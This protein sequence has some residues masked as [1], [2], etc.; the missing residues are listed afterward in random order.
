MN[1]TPESERNAGPESLGSMI[2]ALP[3]HPVSSI[4][5]PRNQRRSQALGCPVWVIS[6]HWQVRAMSALPPNNGRVG[7][8]YKSAFGCHSMSTRPSSR[9]LAHR[10][11]SPALSAR[12]LRA[13][14]QQ[15]LS[16]LSPKT[17]VQVLW[18]TKLFCGRPYAQNLENV[19]SVSEFRH[20]NECTHIAAGQSGAG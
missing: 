9:R 7:G 18:N 8:A 5:N 4:R 20:D 2:P 15:P 1:G 6:G 3:S 12:P 17:S 14:P 11:K 10:T 16:S 13:T 19:Q